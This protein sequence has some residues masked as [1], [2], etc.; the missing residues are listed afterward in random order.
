MSAKVE[1]PNTEA[2][3]VSEQQ[4]PGSDLDIKKVIQKS[5]SDVSITDLAKKGFKQ[6]KVLNRKVIARLIIEAVDQAILSRA[7]QIGEKEREK[8][9][10][11]SQAK[12]EEI[13]RDKVS[14]DKKLIEVQASRETAQNQVGKLEEELGQL[15]A[16]LGE[17]DSSIE[18]LRAQLSERDSSI[19]ALRTQ[20][21]ERDMQIGVLREKV[22]N[23]DATGREVVTI[24]A[25]VDERDQELHSLRKQLAEIQSQ[26]DPAPQPDNSLME[27]LAARLLDKLTEQKQPAEGEGEIGDL[28]SSIDG[29]VNKISLMGSMGAGGG[30]EAGVSSTE[31]DLDRLFDRV[32]D[33]EMESNVSKVKVKEAKAGGV[34]GTLARLKEL[35][36][37]GIQDGE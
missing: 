26:P 22:S 21:S 12:F 34:K 8:V 20:L 24:R 16:Q 29:L 31:A 19:E 4:P 33:K 30:G 32:D 25:Q 5:T 23:A 9:I 17:S 7:S 18:A 3:S 10:K 6:V 1:F 36:K 35:Q 14:K 27:S 28:K 15:R 13:A 11:E 37:G 2:V